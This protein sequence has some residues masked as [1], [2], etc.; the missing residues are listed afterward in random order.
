M[1]VCVQYVETY[2][3]SVWKVWYGIICCVSVSRSAKQRDIWIKP[4]YYV[5]GKHLTSKSIW[6]TST[7]G[8]GHLSGEFKSVKY[9]DSVLLSIKIVCEKLVYVSTC[10]HHHHKHL[11]YVHCTVRGWHSPMS[12]SKNKTHTKYM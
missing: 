1:C 9:S 12:K 2:F 8:R 4:P 7:V 3:Q 10:N 11:H 6:L 5:S